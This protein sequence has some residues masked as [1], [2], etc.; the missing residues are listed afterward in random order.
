MNAFNFFS[1]ILSILSCS[2][3]WATTDSRYNFIAKTIGSNMVLQRDVTASLYGY[4]KA[5]GA[6][7][8][9]E[10][11]FLSQK[12]TTTSAEKISRTAGGHFWKIDIPPTK[13]GFS[14]YDFNI[15]SSAR[16]SA[17]L[18]NIVFGDVYLCGGQS[19]MQMALAGDYNAES[20]TTA[21]DKYPYLR[22]FTVGQDTSSRQFK[23]PQDD[24]YS[25]EQPWTVAS[26]KAVNLDGNAWSYFSAV[27]WEFGKNVFDQSLGSAVPVGL[28]SNNWGG[29][30]VQAWAPGID[31]RKCDHGIEADAISGKNVDIVSSSKVQELNPNEYGALYNAMITPF[32]DMKFKGAIWYQGESNAGSPSTYPCMQDQMVQAW[33]AMW[34]ALPFLY[35]QISTWTAGGNSVVSNFRLTQATIT[36]KTP[37]SAMITAADIGDPDS[38][39]GDIHPRY[40]MEV[41]RRLA[42][43]ASTLIYGKPADEVPFAG[44]MIESIHAV[45]PSSA[46]DSSYSVSVTFTSTSCGPNGVH[47]QPAQ[48]CPPASQAQVGGC[49]PVELVYDGGLAVLASVTVT[50]PYSVSFA[51]TVPT[52]GIPVKLNYGLGDYPLMTIYNSLDVPLMPFTAAIN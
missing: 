16:E 27:C 20:E 14:A 3:A 7:I 21:A 30:Y 44:P 31:M 22:L 8:S 4:S 34:G 28:V 47:L 50:G 24:L 52:I 46:S 6:T 12:L 19:N 48:V 11:P 35:T 41:G 36:N 37:N 45:P 39:Y 43:A 17:V 29:T 15:T 40:K 33:R 10:S 25:V 42:L 38:P 2:V 5:P 13:G 51:P 9:I 1:L 26:S 32:R 18:T 49:G 23:V